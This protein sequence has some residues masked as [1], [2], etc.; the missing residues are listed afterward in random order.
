MLTD[1]DLASCQVDGLPNLSRFGAEV[2][3]IDIASSIERTHEYCKS[4]PNVHILQADIVNLPFQKMTFDYVFCKLTICYVRD[5][6]KTFKELSALVKPSGRLFISVPDKSNLAFVVRLKDFLRVTHCIPRGLLLNLCW[7]FA[8][9]LSLAKKIAGNP[10]NSIRT[11]AFFL[12]NA[13]HPCFMTRH[14]KEEVVNWFQKEYFDEVSLVQGMAHLIHVR[15]TR[16]ILQGDS[17][18]VPSF[19]RIEEES[20]LLPDM[21][22]V[23]IRGTKNSSTAKRMDYL[24]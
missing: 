18:P 3:G 17:V 8:P 23:C 14:T 21:V 19:R 4:A 1:Q 12:F 11:N 10:M 15:G 2:Y 13:L 9:V 7:A 22:E 20:K 5:H 24:K 6:E 16:G